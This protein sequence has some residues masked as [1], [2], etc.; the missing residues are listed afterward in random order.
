MRLRTALLASGLA[1]AALASPSS[2]AP[3]CNIVTDAAG[4]TFLLRYQ[5][6]PPG[7]A[8]GPQEDSLD[9]VS[10]DLASDGK[11]LTAVIRLK[12][13]AAAAS[14]SPGGAGYDLNFTSPNSKL[15]LFM[16]AT[17]TSAGEV[18][19]AGFKDPVGAGGINL[20]TL[21][22][23]LSP[24]TGVFDAAKNEIRMHVPL[25]VFDAQGGIKKDNLLTFGEVTSGRAA[26]S[27][28]VFAD[29]AVAEAATYKV[30]A[31]SCV[32]PGK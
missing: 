26:G 29:A 6:I 14:T 27:R 9:I 3:K 4:D 20:T 11:V 25:A 2:A 22:T 1:V 24:A 30:G 12:N 8:Y 13:L 7:G 5:E 10:A 23:I 32:K 15:G 18:F 17:R 19:E 28:S 31:D 16:R 21:S